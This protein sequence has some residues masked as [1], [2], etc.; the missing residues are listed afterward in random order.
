MS[1]LLALSLWFFLLVALFWFD[2]AKEPK[3]SWALWL[4]VIWMFFLA[5]R[6]P[7]Q[8]IGGPLGSVAG[9]LEDGNPIDR[10]IFS[11]II[12]MSIGVL[13]SRS[14]KWGSFLSSNLA[15]TA[16]LTFALISVAW[17]DFPF[18]A[19][20]RWFR[21][22]GNYM[23][24]LVAL[25]DAR[26]FEAVQTLLRRLGY[27]LMPLSVLLV[28][29]FP[30]LSRAYDDWTGVAL[31][32]GPTTGKNLLGL[33]AMLCGVFF[34]WDV[35][36]RW[37]KRKERRTKRVILVDIAHIAMALWLVKIAS[38]TTAYVCFALGC[39]VVLA[40]QSKVLRRRPK[41]LLTAIPAVF[42][43]YLFVALGLGMSGA[44]AGAIGKDPT[45][46][47]RTKIW[48]FVLS[49]HSN[50]IIGAGYESFWIGNRLQKFWS[51]AGLGTINEAHNGFL[52]VYLQL[53]GIGVLLLSGFLIAGYRN[54][55]RLLKTPSLA[56]YSLSVWLVLLFF[57]ITEAGFRS[58]LIWATFLLGALVVP[59]RTK[60]KAPRA[61]EFGV[62]T[63]GSVANL[64]PEAINLAR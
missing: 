9:S 26:P 5:T 38:S 55:A 28:K 39:A 11:C 30:D 33:I 45:L 7:S 52:E 43:L 37:P 8:W 35:V 22:L 24:I 57:S 29:Y 34:F 23:V 48:S 12:L 13:V 21:D 60:R 31:I 4:P 63:T 40:A 19:F 53:G 14:F 47:D 18:V 41:F 15:L 17:S 51:E 42:F 16:Y 61:A 46:T 25:S 44:L 36:A 62:N 54:A 49:M 1:P 56:S 10:T 59:R 27:L 58:G 64:S 3:M 50:P 20:K 6:L 32:V 2:P